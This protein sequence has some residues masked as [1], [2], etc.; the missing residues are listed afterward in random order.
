MQFSSD[1]EEAATLDGAWAD[2]TFQETQ[3]SVETNAGS[4]STARNGHT[5]SGQLRADSCQST[6]VL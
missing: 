2:E 5:N 3:A 1:F 6:G 4:L